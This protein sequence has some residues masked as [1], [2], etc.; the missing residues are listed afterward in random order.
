MTAE[1]RPILKIKTMNK[2]QLR[3]KSKKALMAYYDQFD[4]QLS[5]S[6]TYRQAIHHPVC[7][8]YGTK[9]FLDIEEANRNVQRFLNSA[10]RRIFGCSG[11]KKGIRL[12]GIGYIEGAV[13]ASVH[14]LPRL[15][16]HMFIGGLDI[17]CIDL[18][19]P[20]AAYILEQRLLQE[21]RDSKWGYDQADIRL[22]GPRGKKIELPTIARSRWQG[23]IHKQYD[24]EQSERLI[25][26]LPNPTEND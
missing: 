23:Y 8:N 7:G 25:F 9:E 2:Y 15:H 4:F 22:I 12:F 13:R 1:V 24:P 6:G 14:G 3:I 5:F 11:A 20:E 17:E 19:D 18:L 26:C 21:W 16:N 10:S